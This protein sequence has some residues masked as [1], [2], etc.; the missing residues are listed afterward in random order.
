MVNSSFKLFT[1]PAFTLNF[2]LKN[3]IFKIVSTGVQSLAVTVLISVSPLKSPNL[4][5]D[6]NVYYSPAFLLS[7]VEIFH[8]FFSY[9]IFFCFII[10][11]L[12]G[13]VVNPR[14]INDR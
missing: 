5:T 9:V 3:F 2:F 14:K 10:V 8:A 6:M 12:T 7:Y 4:S 13:D 1:E 11:T